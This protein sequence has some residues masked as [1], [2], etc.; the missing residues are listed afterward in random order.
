MA[1]GLLGVCAEAG[2]GAWARLQCA[3]AS[4]GAG[5]ERHARRRWGGTRRVRGVAVVAGSRRRLGFAR[6]RRGQCAQ[7]SSASGAGQGAARGSSAPC[8]RA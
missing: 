1:L 3:R 7:G 4:R 2:S 8:T 6:G 5:P